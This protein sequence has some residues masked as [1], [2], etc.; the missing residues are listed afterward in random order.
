L[1]ND[2]RTLAPAADKHIAQLRS[3]HTD[4]EPPNAVTRSW[5]KYHYLHRRVIA[6]TIATRVYYQRAGRQSTGM[7]A[8]R[9]WDV[10]RTD[11]VLSRTRKGDAFTN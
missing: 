11:M 3:P 9:F 6:N 1:Q 2:F 10:P 8:R 4:A 5:R 7:V